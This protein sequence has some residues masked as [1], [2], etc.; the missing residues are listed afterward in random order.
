[1]TPFRVLSRFVHQTLIQ[2]PLDPLLPSG[3]ILATRYQDT[4]FVGRSQGPT[5]VLYGRQHL[6]LNSGVLPGQARLILTP[7][8][9]V[10][11]HQIIGTFSLDWRLMELW[12][13]GFLS[14]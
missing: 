5:R 9:E 12:S 13:V 14:M 6:P 8:L 4:E 10:P 2:V 7:P 3:A 11:H 1:M